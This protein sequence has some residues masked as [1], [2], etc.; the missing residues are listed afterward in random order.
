MKLTAT[1]LRKLIAEEVKRT[2]RL[3]EA[4]ELDADLIRLDMVSIINAYDGLND[5]LSGKLEE[6]LFDELKLNITEA[7]SLL[8]DLENNIEELRGL[9]GA[10]PQRPGHY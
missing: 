9:R 2:R 7:K 6:A 4:A 8:E 5:H 1:Q 10:A 3:H